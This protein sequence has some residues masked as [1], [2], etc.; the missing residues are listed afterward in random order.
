MPI[1]SMVIAIIPGAFGLYL[2]H[3][4]C[5]SLLDRVQQ[6]QWDS[7]TFLVRTLHALPFTDEDGTQLLTE[8]HDLFPQLVSF[9][10]E[11]CAARKLYLKRMGVT[12]QS[13][14]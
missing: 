11:S 7:R 13:L 12:G 6:E 4:A 3:Y 10:S 5:A 14:L 9:F 8:L 1:C 2:L